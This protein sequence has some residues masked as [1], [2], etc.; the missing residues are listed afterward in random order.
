MFIF[1]GSAVKLAQLIYP[2]PDLAANH[3]GNAGHLC[4]KGVPDDPA[5]TA[6][7]AARRPSD[8]GI[9]YDCRGIQTGHPKNRT[10]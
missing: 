6:K 3:G 9:S 8:G 2:P 1:R 7:G 4:P 10:G 5:S